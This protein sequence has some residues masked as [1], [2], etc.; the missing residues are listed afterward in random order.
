[1]ADKKR[2]RAII[3]G[4]VQGVNFRMETWR[5]AEDIGVYGWVRNKSDGSVEALLE[6]DSAK[7]D[8]MLE[9]CRQGPPI[10]RVTDIEVIEEPYE[11]GFR[12]FSVR[13]TK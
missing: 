5:A 10:A 7:V 11:G 13:Y 8:E 6:G 1:M 12:D 4:R 2:V 3:T 9:W